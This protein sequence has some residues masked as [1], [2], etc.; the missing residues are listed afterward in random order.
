MADF[1]DQK[2]IS[3]MNPSNGKDWTK[4]VTISPPASISF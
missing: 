1:K 2:D 4:F 3:S